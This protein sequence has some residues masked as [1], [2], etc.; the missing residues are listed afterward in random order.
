VDTKTIVEEMNAVSSKYGPWRYCNIYLQD[1]VYTMSPKIIGDEIKLRRVIQCI[2]DH[3]GGSLEGLRILDLGCGEGIYS[4]ELARHKAQVVAMDGRETHLEKVRFVKRALSLD[5]LEVV[6]DDVR[7]LSLAK[8]GKFDVVL[9]LGILYH[10]KAPDVFSFA[11]RLSEVCE[12]LCIVDTRINLHPKT[13][14]A[15]GGQTYWGSWGEEHWPGDSKELKLSRIAAS[16]DDE[17]NFWLSRPTLYNLLFHGGFTSVYECHIPAEPTKPEDRFTFVAIK[18]RP[19]SLFG[20]PQMATRKRDDMPERPFHEH[21]RTFNF[22]RGLSHL[23]PW[24][25]RRLTKKLIGL[26]N[27]LT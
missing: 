27:E 11:E 7:N 19:C 14:Y 6:Q 24:R 4:I 8:Y 25:V 26:D 22:L 2:S 17:K 5:N 1:G 16:L 3:A 23:L 21:G 9:C 20:A 18:G 13:S 12:K 10:L 15:Y